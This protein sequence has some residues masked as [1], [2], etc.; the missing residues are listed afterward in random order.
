MFTDVYTAK[1][2]MPLMHMFVLCVCVLLPCVSQAAV[3]DALAAAAVVVSGV[4][5]GLQSIPK[6]SL[7]CNEQQYIGL[8]DYS[9]DVINPFEAITKLIKEGE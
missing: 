4:Q 6:D 2:P 9:N 5:D 7:V 1:I 8:E 3:T